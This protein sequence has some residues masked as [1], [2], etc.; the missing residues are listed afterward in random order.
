M[1]I[2]PEFAADPTRLSAITAFL[3]L[4]A[5][6][7]APPI[8]WLPLAG[9]AR[10]LLGALLAAQAAIAALTLA[11]TTFVLQG[12]GARRDAADRVYG[13]YVRRSRVYPIFYLSVGAVGVTGA[14]LAGGEF[15][16]G[17]APVAWAAPGFANLT[18]IAVASF[19]ANLVLAVELFRRALQLTRPDE[20]RKLRRGVDECDVRSAVQAFLARKRR[21]QAEGSTYGGS[22]H[23]EWDEIIPLRGEG[24]ANEALGALL[25]DAVRA[26][27]EWRQGDFEWSLA[28]VSELVEY[29]MDELEREGI[30]WDLPGSVP[31]WPPLA[32]WHDT[33][34][35]FREEV[36]TRGRPWYARQLAMVDRRLVLSGLKRSSGELFSAGLE[37]CVRNYDLAYG[38]RDRQLRDML[39]NFAAEDLER[40]FHSDHAGDVAY[41]RE[42]IRHHAGLLFH[43]MRREDADDFQS[44]RKALAEMLANGKSLWA[45][46][47]KPRPTDEEVEDIEQISRYVVMGLA[48]YSMSLA[49]AGSLVDPDP[50]I[51]AARSEY[52]SVQRLAGTLPR[53]PIMHGSGIVSRYTGRFVQ[54]CAPVNTGNSGG[55]I[56]SAC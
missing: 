49:E 56:V 11:V 46:E 40:V 18:L 1:G 44:L 16:G 33:I 28:S 3:G 15:V 32:E 22:S 19:A 7:A 39:R 30:D 34:D 52:Q 55:P 2:T 6:V 53:H 50:Y 43:A 10:G 27:G 26:M 24:A 51:E 17:G 9:E 21:S 31:Y 5:L 37:G 29:A 36:I 12:V 45:H 23:S 48:G 41:L 25:R 14:V 38:R 8:E 13:E 54:I 47:R 42:V 4:C 20:W 35:S